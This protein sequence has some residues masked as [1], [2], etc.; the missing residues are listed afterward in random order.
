MARKV[1]FSFYYIEDNWRAAQIRNMGVIEGNN[2]I[3]DN[4]WE[5]VKKGGD[6]AI[7]NWIDSQIKGRSCTI[8]LIGKN[9]AGRKWIDY[10]INKSWEEGKGVFGIY[11]HGLKNSNG[12]QS[13][14]GKNPFSDIIAVYDPPYSES[15]DVYDY[16]SR[17]I[18]KWVE[19]AI[20]QRS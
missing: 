1:F 16:I 6:K 14:K 13:D 8:V 19:K 7:Q 20:K 3:S 15:K 9:T 12:K 2:A 10:E 11:I 17:N 5:A 4:D 18:E